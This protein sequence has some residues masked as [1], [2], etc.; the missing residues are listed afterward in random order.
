M[1]SD[2]L[3]NAGIRR[4]KGGCIP[5]P[6]ALNAR[7]RYQSEGH[8]A[9]AP[10]Y[11][12]VLAK[13]RGN[14]VLGLT[15]TPERTDGFDV[16]AIF[17]DNLAYHATIGDG[18]AEESL[19]PFHYIGIKDTVDFRQIPWRNGHFDLAELEQRVARSERMDRLWSSLEEHPAASTLIF[20]CSRRHAVFTRDWLREKGVSSAAVFSG[21]GGDSYGESLQRLRS[22]VL[23]TLCVVDMFNEG[24][25]FRLLTAL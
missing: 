5:E 13:I 14:F 1:I 10:S 2:P 23:K 9:H 3:T 4:P 17:D 25:T 11:R 16:A 18:I 7:L 22:G 12:R 8:H 20:C 19:V 24:W 6:D 21:G 15:A